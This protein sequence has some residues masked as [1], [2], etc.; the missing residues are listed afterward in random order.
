MV[1]LLNNNRL[2]F[3]ILKKGGI[4]FENITEFII[5]IPGP[6]FLILYSFFSIIC[7]LFG[8]IINRIIDKS[9]EDTIPKPDSIDKYEI[10]VLSGG[11]NT[12]IKLTIID[13]LNRDII[14]IKGYSPKVISI[15]KENYEPKTPIEKIVYNYIKPSKNPK[16]FF[17]DLY[18]KN[19]IQKEINNIQDY[20]QEK[21][22]LLRD[23]EIKK[24]WFTCLVIFSIVI[25][26]G[27]TKMYFGI[28]FGKPITYL[29]I[30]MFILSIFTINSLKPNKLLISKL[31]KRFLKLT[32]NH[33]LWAKNEMKNNQ[34]PN[35]FDPAFGYAL[36]GIAG[37]G[38]IDIFSEFSKA[39]PNNQNSFSIVSSGCG[40][41][42]G[43]GS[44]SGDSGSS[45]CGGGGCGG[46][47]GGGGE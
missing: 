11:I 7:I 14:E 36:Y 45:G 43:G 8:V 29:I 13:L 25:V 23:E 21:H 10:A 20:L 17:K 38:V 16:Q 18:L 32:K 19:Y 24:T 31:G 44:D 1:C 27:G 47:G 33:F 37:L 40:G 35:G 4:M 30:F 34:I 46:C 42:C 41:G 3:I 15:K 26:L 9:L 12:V 39:F 2:L 5:R 22:L 6:K 28:Y